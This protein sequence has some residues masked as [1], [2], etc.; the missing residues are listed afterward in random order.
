[1]PQRTRGG[2]EEGSV[3][4]FLESEK[5]VTYDQN[6]AGRSHMNI[7]SIKCVGIDNTIYN[8]PFSSSETLNEVNWEGFSAGDGVTIQN[9]TAGG[10][11]DPKVSVGQKVLRFLDESSF[12]SKNYIFIPQI[13]ISFRLAGGTMAGGTDPD[14]GGFLEIFTS[15]NKSSWTTA[16]AKPYRAT[17]AG[18]SYSIL[19]TAG[20]ILGSEIAT[21]RFNHYYIDIDTT[22]FN[23]QR[24][25]IKFGTTLGGSTRS[26]LMHSV[27]FSSQ[28]RGEYSSNVGVSFTNVTMSGFKIILSARFTGTVRY[29]CSSYE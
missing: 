27:E 10:V 14:N 25:Y 24:A 19:S 6:L 2:I 11:G 1:M 4:F 28:D 9:T 23:S 20:K 3:T 7:P 13:R 17:T 21:D 22:V 15:E 26:I 8:S 5:N 29:L 12:N 16:T 18:G